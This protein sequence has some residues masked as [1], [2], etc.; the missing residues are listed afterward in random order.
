MRSS[1]RL[2]SSWSVI[3]SLAGCSP[4]PIKTEYT[5]SPEIVAVFA[6]Q[7]R[8]ADYSLARACG[9]DA[10]A[11]RARAAAEQTPATMPAEAGAIYKTALVARA[12]ETAERPSAPLCEKLR[13]RT[14]LAGLFAGGRPAAEP[15]RSL[16]ARGAYCAEGSESVR[17]DPTM[18]AG[19]EAIRTNCRRGD[20]IALPSD[21]IGIIASVCDLSK[22]TPAS[23]ANVFCTIGSV[24]RIRGVRA[25]R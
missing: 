13:V 16:Q 19:L 1:L 5:A 11:V 23:G 10:G 14:D 15:V 6:G 9:A 22:P 3:L 12:A 8:G 25:K 20:T 18:S 2:L 24:R 4:E 17:R 21:A 7:S